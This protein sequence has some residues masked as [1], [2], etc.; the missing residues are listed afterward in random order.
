MPL[1]HSKLRSRFRAIISGRSSCARPKA[2]YD[3]SQHAISRQRTD[4]INV[5][6]CLPP[7][8]AYLIAPLAWV[9]S[10]SRSSHTAV[11]Y[12]ASLATREPIRSY[13]SFRPIAGYALY[14]SSFAVHA[15]LFFGQTLHSSLCSGSLRLACRQKTNTLRGSGRPD[16]L[17]PNCRSFRLAWWLNVVDRS[18][19]GLVIAVIV[20]RISIQSE[21]NHWQSTHYCVLAPIATG[22]SVKACQFARTYSDWLP[23]PWDRLCGGSPVA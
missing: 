17:K 18:S 11:N 7:A 22:P 15:V 2:F 20:S 6:V 14:A 23:L 3:P 9:D 21:A 13:S 16:A 4:L 1:V 10:L 12:P 19:G 5:A 8:M